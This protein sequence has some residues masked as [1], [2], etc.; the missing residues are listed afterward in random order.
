MISKPEQLIGRFQPEADEPLAQM[1]FW[2]KTISPCCP[3]VE[4]SDVAFFDS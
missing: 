3:T 4:L 1:R 2:K